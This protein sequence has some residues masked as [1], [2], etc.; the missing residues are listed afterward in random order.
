MTKNQKKFVT[1]RLGHHV[2][3]G[4]Y[5]VV[6]NLGIGEHGTRT[7][8]IRLNGIHYEETS[9]SVDPIHPIEVSDS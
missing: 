3:P 4:R 9:I 8:L 5:E 7:L 6:K 2:G 1:I